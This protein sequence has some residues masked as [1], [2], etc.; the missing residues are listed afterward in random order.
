MPMGRPSTI[1]RVIDIM[2]PPPASVLIMPT[3]IPDMMRV[4]III[5]LSI[6]C[7]V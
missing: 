5:V 1:N 2:A 4:K 6:V 3:T 7:N